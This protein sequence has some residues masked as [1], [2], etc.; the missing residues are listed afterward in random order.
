MSTIRQI[1]LMT[2]I[3]I[4]AIL[5]TLSA[6]QLE[7]NAGAIF[8][9]TNSAASNQIIAFKRGILVTL[10]FSRIA[11]MGLEA[12]PTSLSLIA[13]SQFFAFFVYAARGK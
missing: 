2:T 12:G 13:K 8:V 1:V 6:A 4:G 7:R 5:P 10:F 9:M 3:A 11:S